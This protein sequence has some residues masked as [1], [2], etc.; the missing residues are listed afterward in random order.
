M[1]ACSKFMLR[2]LRCLR[3]ARSA[4]SVE[5]EFM[6]GRAE[7]TWETW[8]YL[9][10]AAFELIEL[11]AIIA[12]EVV[13]MLLAGHLIAGRVS[14][15]LDRGQ[16]LIFD[17]CFDVAVNSGNSQTAMMP[18]R[19]RQCFLQR[20]RSISLAECLADG[21]FLSCVTDIHLVSQKVELLASH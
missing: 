6:T 18:L 5:K 4:D 16:P 19:R 20:E 1:K 9:L 13:M 21:I 12:M 8:F 7:A 10:Y 11:A 3:R 15:N 14:R 2:T 17:Q